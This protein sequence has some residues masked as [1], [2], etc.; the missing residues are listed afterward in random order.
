MRAVLVSAMNGSTAVK[1][2]DVAVPSHEAGQVLW[3]CITPVARPPECGYATSVSRHGPGP[4]APWQVR[5]S[6]PHVYEEWPYAQDDRCPVL[7]HPGP[8]LVEDCYAGLVW[9]AKNANELGV[10]AERLLI[11]GASRGGGLAAGTALLARD[12]AFPKVSHQVL[13]SPMLDDRFETHNSRMLD[14]EGIWTATP[15]SSVGTRC[16]ASGAA[17]RTFRRTPRRH[18]RRTSRACHAPTWTPARSSR[19]VTRR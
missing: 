5:E 6:T 11:A 16:W 12:R 15:M 10:D 2:S 8:T 7:H 1:L 9:A 4:T 18:A 14:N 13:I 17:G 3:R 19:S